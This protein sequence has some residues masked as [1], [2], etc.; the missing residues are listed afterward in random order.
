[1]VIRLTTLPATAAARSS[2]SKDLW[3][4]SP[5]YDLAFII[6]SSALLVFPHLFSRFGELSNVAVDLVVT[7]FIGGRTCSPPT[8]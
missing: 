6:F 7:A 4:V 1:M 5:G 2:S 8:R 3:L